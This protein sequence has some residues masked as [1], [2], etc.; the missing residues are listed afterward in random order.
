MHIHAKSQ[1]V[2]PAPTT[3]ISTILEAPSLPTQLI[4]NWVSNIQPSSPTNCYPRMDTSPHNQIV[5]IMKRKHMQWKP[6]SLAW[7]PERPWLEIMLKYSPT[8]GHTKSHVSPVHVQHLVKGME[9][10]WNTDLWKNKPWGLYLKVWQQT[11]LYTFSASSEWEGGLSR[12]LK[13]SWIKPN[14]GPCY[15]VILGS[16]W[17]S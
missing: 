5:I 14:Y 11:A 16:F 12:R 8:I 1:L 3:A 9:F 2:T 10:I 7:Q 4:I 6:G 13:P 17:S 15:P